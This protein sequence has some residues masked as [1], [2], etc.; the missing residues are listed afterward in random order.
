MSTRRERFEHYLQ[1]RAVK[2]HPD[3]VQSWYLSGYEHSELD[4]VAGSFI[5]NLMESD[6]DPADQLA[7]FI[8]DLTGLVS[9]LRMIQQG[10]EVFDNNRTSEAA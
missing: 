6:R 5:G 8:D 1:S 7:D 4:D 10:F 3:T 2:K 9:N